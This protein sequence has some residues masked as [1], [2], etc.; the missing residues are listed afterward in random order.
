MTLLEG[1]TLFRE[2]LS[3]LYQTQEID[4]YYKFLLEHVLSRN[5]IQLALNPNERLDK[6]EISNSREL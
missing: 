2:Q 1:R 4:F 3:K 6:Q 5:P